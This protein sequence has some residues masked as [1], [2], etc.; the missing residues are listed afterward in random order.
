MELIKKIYQSYVE[1]AFPLTCVCCGISTSSGERFICSLC[2]TERFENA[3]SKQGDIFPATVMFVNTMWYFDKGGYLQDLLH[4]LKYH[5]V[6]GVGLEL[7]YLM[8][9]NFLKGHSKDELDRIYNLSP[10][11]V[12][13]PLHPSKKR[14]RGYNQARALGEGVA[15]STGWEII[16]SG[17]IQ[18]NKKT[19]TQTGLNMKQRS[20]NLRGA[21]KITDS[22]PLTDRLPV[23]VDDVFTTG[24]TTFELART[25]YEVN[26]QSSGILTVAR[27]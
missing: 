24:A 7:G 3:A 15:K 12:P 20:E 25:V 27:A 16:A 8:G 11:I 23:I 1:I 6:R 18:R 4:K 9:A 2:R 26:G 21:F 19:K 14:K 22:E 17:V 13:V 10:V 5:H